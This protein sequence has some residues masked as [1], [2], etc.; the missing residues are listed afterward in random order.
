[1][2]IKTDYEIGQEIK[3][4]AINTIGRITAF[5]YGETGLQYQVA[6]FIDGE[7][8]SLYLYPSELSNT[9]GTENLGFRTT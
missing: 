7:R 9:T 5:Y 2:E 8:K 4:K 3:I 6:Y 1:M